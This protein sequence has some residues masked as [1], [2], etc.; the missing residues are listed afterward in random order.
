MAKSN[1]THTEEKQ[2]RIDA[3][4]RYH[5]G[6][7][8]SKICKSLGRSR[9]WLQKWVGRYNNLDKSSDKEWFK[10]E[11]RAP[12]NIHRKIDSEVEQLIIKVRKSLME[13]KTEDTKYRCM[14][15]LIA[16]RRRLMSS[17][18]SL[19]GVSMRQSVWV[20]GTVGLL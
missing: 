5:R 4:N 2:E 13:G 12:K 19:I 9:S 16:V 10:E 11:S 18:F 6:E 15:C 3:V 1:E 14:A 7:R 8:L 20:V 17:G